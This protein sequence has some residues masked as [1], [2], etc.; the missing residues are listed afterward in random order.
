MLW[1]WLIFGSQRL[2][3]NRYGPNVPL[4]FG[5]RRRSRRRLQVGPAA[6][7]HCSDGTEFFAAIRHE[8]LESDCDILLHDSTS[9]LWLCV[10]ASQ[11]V[12]SASTAKDA[13]INKDIN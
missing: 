8:C 10:P 4:P 11:I 5:S 9:S 12:V 6:R 1:Q 7:S 2:V 3:S 13:S